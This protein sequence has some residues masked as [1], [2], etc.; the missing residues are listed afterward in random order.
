MIGFEIGGRM[1][2]RYGHW[3]P[4]LTLFSYTSLM[5]ALEWWSV[6]QVG[7]LKM[8]KMSSSYFP[9]NLFYLYFIVQHVKGPRFSTDGGP[10]RADRGK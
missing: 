7:M 3:A 9:A 8:S 10:L 1:C 2:G 5:A 6:E 4:A